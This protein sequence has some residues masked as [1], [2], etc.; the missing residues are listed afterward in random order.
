M[1][2]TRARALRRAL[3]T[4]TQLFREFEAAARDSQ[5]R[6]LPPRES[7]RVVIVAGRPRAVGV[8]IETSH[9][10]YRDFDLSTNGTPVVWAREAVPCEALPHDNPAGRDCQHGALV[11]LDYLGGNQSEP[12][13]LVTFQPTTEVRSAATSGRSRRPGARCGRSPRPSGG[14][15]VRAVPVCT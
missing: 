2:R 9:S 1:E 5:A 4:R 15:P 8:D 14:R 3:L 7:D 11:P 6:L 10:M 12:F 13:G